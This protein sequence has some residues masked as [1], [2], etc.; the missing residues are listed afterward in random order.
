MKNIL[1][2]ILKIAAAGLIAFV[3]LNLFT[4]FY[5]RMP[6]RVQDTD[7]VTYYRYQPDSS[8]FQAREGISAGHVN[9]EGYLNI[10][11]Y[12]PDMMVDVLIM[13]SSH[14]EALQLNNGQSCAELLDSQK[15]NMS[16]YNIGMSAHWF[17]ENAKHVENALKKYKPQKYLIMEVPSVSISNTELEEVIQKKM[18]PAALN[19]T[20]IWRVLKS[21]PF[22]I[23]AHDQIHKMIQN[24]QTPVSMESSDPQKNL[25]LLNQ[26]L[27][28]I[29]GLAK[30]Y[31]VRLLLLY[32]PDISLIKD[33]VIE[34]ASTK[35]EVEKYKELCHEHHI[36]FLDM[37]DRFLKEYQEHHI[38]PYGFINTS[39]GKGHLN[40]YG[41][42]MIADELS[43]MIQE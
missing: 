43:R 39:V 41:H 35:Q 16:V 8:Y 32:H 1:L 24:R 25:T 7:E 12:T 27:S 3:V 15:Q 21:F 4:M 20:G 38:L 26:V 9:N 36:D 40:R 42:Q 14:M 11:N 5:Y 28:E 29:A 30:N 19:N 10:K 23:L 34:F 22:L 2:Y 13:G 18:N 37:S 6:P 17:P 33:N 31:G